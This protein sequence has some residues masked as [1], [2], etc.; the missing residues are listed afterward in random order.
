MECCSRPGSCHSA[1]RDRREG[2]LD[3]CRETV[4]ILLHEP[5]ELWPRSA[6]S[7]PC[8]SI[9]RTA[10]GSPS[11]SQPRRRPARMSSAGRVRRAAPRVPWSARNSRLS[12]PLRSKTP[13]KLR[14]QNQ[15][16]RSIEIAL[17]CAAS[18]HPSRI[19]ATSALCTQRRTPCFEHVVLM[20]AVNY[21]LIRLRIRT[22]GAA[23]FG[24]SSPR[25][26]RPLSSHS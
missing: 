11:A 26:A 9:S 7:W 16:W 21:A 13:A 18:T 15:S 6:A 24:Q 14:T 2:T 25:T 3:V 5:L 20:V 17:I 19:L 4:G 10:P 23:R 22:A 12:H 1:V 8:V